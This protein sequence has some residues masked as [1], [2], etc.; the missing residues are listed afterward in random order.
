MSKITY[1]LSKDVK[2]GFVL[3]YRIVNGI[4][5]VDNEKDAALFLAEPNR[6]QKISFE[7]V[8]EIKEEARKVIE[9][10]EDVE[11]DMKAEE[12]KIEIKQEV[13]AKEEVNPDELDDK[14]KTMD[15]TIV[16]ALEEILEPVKKA[17]PAPIKR[18]RG[19]PK[20]KLKRRIKK[21]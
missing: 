9:S 3:N 10:I 17:E 16:E 5:G 12:E 6:F 14:E 4:F 7:K 19:R 2:E 20:S 8:S 15:E 13:E 18:G 21:D 11:K 1:F